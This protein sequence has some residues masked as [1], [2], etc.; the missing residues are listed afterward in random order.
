MKPE[1]EEYLRA[2]R[3]AMARAREEYPGDP[4][5]QEE[6]L[7][8][9]GWPRLADAHAEGRREERERI[10]ARVALAEDQTAPVAEW[11]E[12]RALS[13]DRP[14]PDELAGELV[15]ARGTGELP[16]VVRGW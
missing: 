10:R 8:I 13:E 2:A 4:A 14:S 15:Q 3:Q 12:E 5:S 11:I 16:V 9:L 7:R 6:L 1:A